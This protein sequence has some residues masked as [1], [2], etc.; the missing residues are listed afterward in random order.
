M[1]VID[2]HMLNICQNS[3][4]WDWGHAHQWRSHDYSTRHGEQYFLINETRVP[5]AH[6]R[7]CLSVSMMCTKYKFLSIRRCCVLCIKY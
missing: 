2:N 6:V 5:T 3:N 4:V 1:M 7:A